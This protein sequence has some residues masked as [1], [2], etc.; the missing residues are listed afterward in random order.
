MDYL[1]E[2]GFSEDEISKLKKLKRI[3]AVETGDVLFTILSM[4]L[5]AGITTI[6]AFLSRAINNNLLSTVLSSIVLGVCLLVEIIIYSSAFLPYEI[7]IGLCKYKK[8][9]T[10]FY[11]LFTLCIIPIL[12]GLFA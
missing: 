10:A 2:L 7:Q 3:K 4:F 9:Q 5:V 6:Y 12:T 11:S 8:T 1:L